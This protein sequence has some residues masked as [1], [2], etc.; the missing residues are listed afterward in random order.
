MLI[1]PITS[2]WVSFWYQ[3]VFSIMT[4]TKISV[5]LDLSV[6]DFGFFVSGNEIRNLSTAKTVIS[7]LL[8]NMRHNLTR[9]CRYMTTWISLTII[10]KTNVSFNKIPFEHIIGSI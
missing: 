4:Y 8:K 9:N 10:Q 6:V 7:Y 3:D 1:V 5:V 2:T